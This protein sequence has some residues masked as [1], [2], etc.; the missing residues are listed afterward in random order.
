LYLGGQVSMETVRQSRD[1]RQIDVSE[2]SFPVIANGKCLAYY[3][4]FR[5]ISRSKRALEDL[6]NAQGELAHLSRIT[7]MGEL[8]A[9]IAHEINQPIG[10]IVTN[11]D[12]ALRWLDQ[13]PP[14]VGDARETLDW[15]VRE[16]TRAT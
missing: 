5:D 9:S 6:Q 3:V 14:G 15:I 4:I 8:A 12:A 10:A 16:G 2:V 1:G 11:G 13:S 7:T